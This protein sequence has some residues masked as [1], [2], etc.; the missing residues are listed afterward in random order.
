MRCSVLT[1]RCGEIPEFGQR[2]LILLFATYQIARL[3]S[4][5]RFCRSVAHLSTISV[6]LVFDTHHSH[7]Q[8]VAGK[9][10]STLAKCYN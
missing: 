9:V 4:M 8:E 2:E 7:A 1:D 5:I 6:R 3:D 10:G